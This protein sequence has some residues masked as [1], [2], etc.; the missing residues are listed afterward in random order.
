MRRPGTRPDLSRLVA[1]SV[2]VIRANQDPGGAYLASPSFPAY[3]YSWLRDG[4]FIADAMSLAGETESAEAFFSWCSGIVSARADRVE[5]LIARRRAGED[6]GPDEHLHCRYTV[7]GREVTSEWSNFQLDGY[8]GWLWALGRHADRHGGDRVRWA[9]GAALTTRYVTACWAVP[10]Y[11]WWE[12]RWGR[13]TAT[14]AACSAGL[15]AACCWVELPDEVRAEAG[16]AAARIGA[17]VR[18]EA[19][20]DGRLGGELGDGRLDASLVACAT[21]FRVLEPD[22]PVLSATVTALEETIAHGGV[23]RYPGDTYYGGGEWL[24]LAA[25]LG[26]WYAETDRREDAEAQLAWIVAQA[27]EAGDLPEQVLDHVLDPDGMREWTARWGPPATPLLW[28]HAWFLTLAAEL[29][30]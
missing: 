30:T 11:D 16:E 13:H 7:D 3:G 18:A 29:E 14:L 4:A 6:I 2:E 15:E 22:D 10:C 28:S 5:A 26:W 17:A 24:L 8:G 1:R 9:E 12:E 21:P 23:H 19:V 27:S 25:L 20:V